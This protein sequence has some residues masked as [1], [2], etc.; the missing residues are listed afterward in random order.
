MEKLNCCMHM[1][2]SYLQLIYMLQAW[3]T[4]RYSTEYFQF[5]ITFPVFDSMEK[6]E[7]SKVV[8]V[9]E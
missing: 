9:Y 7:R 3:V 8:S 4:A 5:L 6:F 1:S 2:A